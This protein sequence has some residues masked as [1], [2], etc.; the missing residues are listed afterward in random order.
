MA[1]EGIILIQID[2]IMSDSLAEQELL[3][4]I[5]K[6]IESRTPCDETKLKLADELVCDCRHHNNSEIWLFAGK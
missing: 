6:Y 1:C 2:I 3:Y 4:L 5:Y